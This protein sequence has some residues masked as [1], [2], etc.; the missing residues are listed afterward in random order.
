MLLMDPQG[1]TSMKTGFS[2]AIDSAKASGFGISPRKATKCLGR[3]PK[4]LLQD[5]S[6]VSEL[7]AFRLRSVVVDISFLCPS[8]ICQTAASYSTLSRHVVV[9]QPNDT[10]LAVWGVSQGGNHLFVLVVIHQTDWQQLAIRIW[11]GGTRMIIEE[12]WHLQTCQER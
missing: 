3:T 2:D 9:N 5:L 12:R 1:L 11:C 7:C 8:G 10:L 4:V 6:P